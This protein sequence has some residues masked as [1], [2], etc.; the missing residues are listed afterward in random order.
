MYLPLVLGFSS[1]FCL[2]LFLLLLLLCSSAAV[3]IF[4]APSASSL[5]LFLFFGAREGDFLRALL[6]AEPVQQKSIGNGALQQLGG[7]GAAFARVPRR[8]SIASLSTC[9][10]LVFSGCFCFFFH[11]Y[12]VL[13]LFC[14]WIRYYNVV[15][16]LL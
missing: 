3:C 9:C 14:E 6:G 12:T 4:C 13:E 5:I 7:H 10:Y 8:Y 15:V 11:L 1:W 2:L 16:L